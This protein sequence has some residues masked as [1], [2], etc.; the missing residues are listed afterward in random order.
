MNNNNLNVICLLLSSILGDKRVK[1]SPTTKCFVFTPSKEVEKI[2]NNQQLLRE[3]LSDLTSDK[4]LLKVIHGYIDTM[5]A[6]AKHY[7]KT[8]DFKKAIKS[9]NTLTNIYRRISYE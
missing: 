3:H 6:D 9:V 8:N 4:Y 7:R 5:I 2:D 1:L